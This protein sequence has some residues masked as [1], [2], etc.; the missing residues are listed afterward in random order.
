MQVRSAIL[1]GGLR[2]GAKLPSSR[3][4]AGRLGVARASVVAAYEQL[5][6]EGYL[7]ARTGSG[8][9]VS[10]DLPEPV[11]GCLPAAA[12]RCKRDAQTG[13]ADVLGDDA[14]PA[15]TDER[16]FNTGRTLV[17]AR[18]AEVW[19]RLTHRAVRGF[20]PGDLGYAD[21]SGSS[22]LRAAVSDYLRAARAVRCGPEQ[23]IVTAG[24]QHAIDLTT[25]VILHP[26]DEAW[27]EDP[28]YPLTRQT[29]A[30]AGV[31]VR[32]V[33]VDAHGLDVTAGARVAP[34]ARAAFVTPSHQ[35]PT[36]VVLSMARRLDLLTWAREHS[37]WV[38]EDDYASEF[39]YS[40]RPLASLQGLDDAER[41]IYVGTLNKALF[42][43][44]RLGYVVVPPRLV[45]AFARTRDLMDRQPPSLLQAV[46]AE[47]MRQG[48][49]AA[50]IRRMRLQYRAQRDAL[51]EAL[52]HLAG[53][54][55]DVEM[56]DQGMHLV[57]YLRGGLSDVAVEQAALRAGVVVRAVSRLYVA[58]PP[59]PAIM[60]GFSGYPREVIIPAAARLAEVVRTVASQRAPAVRSQSNSVA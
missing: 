7:A 50:H 17:D 20:G 29:L 46:A 37:A 30:A 21:P 38:V 6:A 26:G 2:P 45:R 8:T 40:G 31:A 28:G 34:C 36:G 27:V 57:A 33:P 14:A 23:V 12:D 10:T 53:D 58:A 16:P 48:H 43:G 47:F 49:L 35:Y 41:V 42:P 32:P 44:L 25:R 55:L 4:L 9:Y 19:R 54:L 51:A 22:E 5:L 15:H 56:P 13:A 52:E 3:D 39:R 18:T 1:A 24:T 60:L 11:E 59:R